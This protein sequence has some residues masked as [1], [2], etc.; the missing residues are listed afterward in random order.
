MFLLFVLRV[1][2]MAKVNPRFSLL[3]ESL[4]KMKYR[5]LNFAVVLVIF[6]VMFTNMAVI[7][8]GDKVAALSEWNS[9]F[10]AVTQLVIGAG[11]GGKRRNR[12]GG[13]EG[14][15]RSVDYPDIYAVSPATAFI[16][17]YPFFAVMVLVVINITVAIIGESYARV[18][19]QR[20]PDSREYAL[21]PS[22]A[23]E[24]FPTT[25]GHQL[26]RGATQRAAHVMG[27][28]KGEL[29][30]GTINAMLKVLPDTFDQECASAAELLKAAEA[31]NL[32][33]NDDNI[34]WIIERYPCIINSSEDLENLLLDRTPAPP[35][36]RK[37]L[38]MLSDGVEDVVNRQASIHAKLDLLIRMAT[39]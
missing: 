8:F 23:L 30:K 3:S 21:T 14:A 27:T 16:W 5:L 37:R 4:D 29:S 25:L 6:V 36:A 7:M 38:E 1:I 2:S 33:L 13:G 12:R 35:G 17:Y 18:K 34:K 15:V 22:E 39:V 32:P 26:Y 31:R 10:V 19:S 11:S 28:N 20:S 24:G 9:A